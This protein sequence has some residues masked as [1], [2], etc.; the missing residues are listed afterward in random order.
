MSFSASE[1]VEISS[2]E[3]SE[4]IDIFDLSLLDSVGSENSLIDNKF[5]D[6]ESTSH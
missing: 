5:P 1:H 3:F 6:F 4:S 2:L